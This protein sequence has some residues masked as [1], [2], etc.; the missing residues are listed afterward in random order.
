VWAA[1]LRGPANQ[2]AQP[3]A[4]ANQAFKIT[5]VAPAYWRVSIHAELDPAKSINRA[6][7]PSL[8]L[9]ATG[10]QAYVG[11]RVPAC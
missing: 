2:V 5:R 4:G 9:A 3:E 11:N 8:N 7:S 10:C 1:R 6:S